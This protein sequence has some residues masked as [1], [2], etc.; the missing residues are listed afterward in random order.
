MDR[1][2]STPTT[3]DTDTASRFS[4]RGR[5]ADTFPEVNFEKGSHHGWSR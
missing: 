1:E 4:R 2:E 3:V 5:I